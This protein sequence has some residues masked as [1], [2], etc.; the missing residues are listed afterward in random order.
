VAAFARASASWRDFLRVL[1]VR[2]S[3]SA[4]GW[5]AC[6]RPVEV[7][8]RLRGFGD[9]PVRLRSHTTDI[10]VLG[11]LAGSDAYGPLVRAVTGDAPPVIVDLGA[12]TGLAAR[13]IHAHRPGGRVVCVEPE[14]GNVAVLRHNLAAI[15]RAVVLPACVGGHE[16]LVRLTT[17]NGEFAFSMV[18]GDGGDVPVVTMERVL[19]EV[20][21][22][23]VD[24]LKCDIEGAERE[25]FE[26]CRSWIG[27]VRV[28]VVECH[29]G[30]S[31]TGLLAM[32]ARNG[33]DF[34]V[35]DRTVTEEFGTEVV[36]VVRR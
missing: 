10:S 31:A 30:L 4:L 35:V 24:I 27:R 21:P 2:L 34:D 17:T 23:P 14:P 28:A 26:D 12:N 15:P 19:A 6:P 16:R 5:L 18:D 33:G 9:E 25:L 22:G 1:R 7:A 20:G 13:W 3:R 8:V 11:E 36:T 29:D 32:L